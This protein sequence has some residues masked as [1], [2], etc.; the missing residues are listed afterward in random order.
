MDASGYVLNDINRILD[1]FVSA[2]K[3]PEDAI[4]RLV[5]KWQEFVRQGDHRAAMNAAQRAWGLAQEMHG[6]MEAVEAAYALAY[7]LQVSG[8][9]SDAEK[10]YLRA[11]TLFEDAGQSATLADVKTRLARL[12]IEQRKIKKAEPLLREAEAA[13]RCEPGDETRY[14]LSSTLGEVARLNRAKSM[15]DQAER[16]ALEALKILQGK[17]REGGNEFSTIRQQTRTRIY[18][19]ELELGFICYYSGKLE[20]AESYLTSAL[21][22]LRDAKDYFLGVYN[23]QSES[24]CLTFLAAVCFLTNR[25]AES[26]QHIERTIELDT[27]E[28]SEILFSLSQRELL[29]ARR[30]FDRRYSFSLSI[31]RRTINTASEATRLRARKLVQELVLSRKGITIEALL[32]A[33]RAISYYNKESNA[34]V[35]EWA[36]TV[37]AIAEENARTEMALNQTNV[38]LNDPRRISLASRKAK[39]NEIEMA[40]ATSM[41]Y[42]FRRDDLPNY[43]SDTVCDGLPPGFAVVE[44]ACFREWDF[45]STE[46]SENHWREWYYLACVIGPKNT[47]IKEVIFLGPQRDIDELVITFRASVTGEKTP[48]EK[49]AIPRNRRDYIGAK[50][51]EIIFDPVREHLKDCRDLLI[52]PDGAL[53]TLPFAVLASSKGKLL[54]DEYNISYLGTAR[55]ILRTRIGETADAAP[56]VVVAAPQFKLRTNWLRDVICEMHR[57]LRLSKNQKASVGESALH[58]RRFLKVKFNS[59]K[60]ARREGRAIAKILGVEPILGS[61]A[62]ERKIKALCAPRYLHIATHGFFVPAHSGPHSDLSEGMLSEATTIDPANSDP[63]LRSG[64]ALAG[65]QSWIEGQEIPEEAEDGLL[66]AIDVSSLNLRGT[67]LVV[68]SAC[69]TGLGQ[70]ELGEGVFGLRRAFA[71]AGARALVVSLWKVPDRQTSKLMVEFY[72]RLQGG[73]CV[74]SALAK[75]Q[76]VIREENPNPFYWASFVCE[77]GLGNSVVGRE[78]HD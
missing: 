55:D 66:T 33:Q 11:L 72:K 16:Y 62:T 73:A 68:L 4:S 56:P 45:D 1:E 65:A 30:H 23:R 54:I 60:G 57:V 35:G 7:S 76:S 32:G 6:Y 41:N 13:L 71:L 61:K 14:I 34:P 51:R 44:Y 48:G 67:E 75:A 3:S 27:T 63:L 42:G 49:A 69:N 77:G 64:L 10:V 19:M 31:L 22:S 40:L 37:R 74:A 59:L 20:K 53:M 38:P 39:Q 26:L 52:S 78:S 21:S 17:F 2:S 29:L 18:L 9:Y 12:Y 36:L 25:I 24:E 5:L 50:L 8:N 47:A 70:V 28:L 15:F 43:V 46:A 58:D